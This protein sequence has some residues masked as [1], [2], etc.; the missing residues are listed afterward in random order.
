MGE[1]KNKRG[2][3]KRSPA[4][5]NKLAS[6]RKNPKTRVITVTSVIKSAYLPFKK[7]FFNPFGII[8]SL[9]K[10]RTRLNQ[11]FES[12]LRQ[13]LRGNFGLGVVKSFQGLFGLD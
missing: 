13:F 7:I 2:I 4:G 3:I 12:V 6:E 9:A 5:G 10:L 8:V 11:I 1:G